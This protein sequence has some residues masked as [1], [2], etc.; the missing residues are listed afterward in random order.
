MRYAMSGI[1]F[2]IVLE[3]S[4]KRLYFRKRKFNWKR[5]SGVQKP[6]WIKE[7]GKYLGKYSLAMWNNNNNNDYCR[8]EFKWGTTEILNKKWKMEK[9]IGIKEF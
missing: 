8:E 9:G 3:R 5:K 6:V 7:F 1:H 4:T 2:Q